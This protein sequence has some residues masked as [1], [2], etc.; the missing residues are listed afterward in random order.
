MLPI[1]MGN[2]LK[3]NAMKEAHRG[4][5]AGLHEALSDSPRRAHP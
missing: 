2:C 4:T 1:I 3:L 5:C